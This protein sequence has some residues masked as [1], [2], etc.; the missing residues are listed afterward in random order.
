MCCPASD[1]GQSSMIQ[2]HLTQQDA[3]LIDADLIN[4]QRI[5]PPLLLQSK[6]TP[7]SIS[8]L[9]NELSRARN[10]SGQ[11]EAYHLI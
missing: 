1:T 5:Q 4:Q 8:P 7:L 9:A 10:M 3:D 6:Y 2:I 11:D